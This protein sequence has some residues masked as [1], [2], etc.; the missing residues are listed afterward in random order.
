MKS[1]RL[2]ASLLDYPESEVWDYPEE[3]LH[4]VS[5]CTEL[6]PS[7]QQRV[8]EFIQTLSSQPLIDSQADYCD[9]F[10]RGR[11][12]SLLL[13]EH[14]H[15]ESRDRGQAMIDLISQY[16]SAG[17]EL[18]CKE[19]PDYIP[20]YLEY[21][22]QLGEQEAINGLK[23][24]APILAL[25]KERLKQRA[26]LYHV[27][28]DVLVDMSGE[29]IREHVLVEKVSNEAKDYTPQALDDVWEEEQIKFMGEEG[30]VSSEQA[31]HQRR[32]A[33]TAAPQYL[34]INAVNGAQ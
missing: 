34:D 28:F 1:L 18:S 23:D 24:V 15:G 9:L 22:S 4:V 19:L 30:C 13:F 7:H 27:L 29:E 10:D 8:V 26:S 5:L 6:K 2:I 17:L 20:T 14:V 32:F 12:L 25:L 11:S 16:K 33:Q 31:Q 3:L 21:I